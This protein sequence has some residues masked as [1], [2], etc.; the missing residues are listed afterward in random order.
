[1]PYV[2]DLGASCG[3]NF[4]NAGSAGTLDGVTIV[5]GH[6]YAETIT[7]QNPAGGWTDRTG[8]ENAD[9]CAWVGAGRRRAGRRTSRLDRH[10]RDAGHLVERL[11]QLPHLASAGLTLHS[12]RPSVRTTTDPRPAPS[13][14][15]SFVR[16]H[17]PEAVV[18]ST[19][20]RA[21]GIQYS[22]V[23]FGQPPYPAAMMLAM[24]GQG[25]R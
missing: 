18:E 4:V 23:I 20:G 9:K 17:R 3:Q 25:T 8:D 13:R 14:P 24:Y 19:T 15:R 12:G 16:T 22:H 1:M 11:E 6:E 10:L 5:E 21:S 7:D 2:T